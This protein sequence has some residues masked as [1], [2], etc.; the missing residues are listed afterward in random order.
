MAGIA[1][2][3]I[4]NVRLTSTANLW[5]LGFAEIFIEGIAAH[6]EDRIA[7]ATSRQRFA[8]TCDVDIDSTIGDLDGWPPNALQEVFTR[9]DAPRALEQTFEQP[10]FRWPE[11]DVARASAH[12]SGLA[13]ELQIAASKRVA[14]DSKPAAP[15]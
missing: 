6:V 10:E 1:P 3:T 7:V 12:P 13:V 5:V 2:A 9:K 4:G 14:R 11:M 15:Q 8:K